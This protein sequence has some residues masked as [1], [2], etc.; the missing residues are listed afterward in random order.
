MFVY[1]FEQCCLAVK[2]TAYIDCGKVSNLCLGEEVIFQCNIT[3]IQYLEWHVPEYDYE[4]DFAGNSFVGM[5]E[6]S[7]CFTAILNGKN[8]YYTSDIMFSQ[9]LEYNNTNVICSD[10]HNLEESKICTATLAGKYTL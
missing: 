8:G 4:M 1:L 7:G 9:K 10:G 3:G 2:T 6:T 5:T